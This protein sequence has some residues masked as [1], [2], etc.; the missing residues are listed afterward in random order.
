MQSVNRED[1]LK[2]TSVDM[3]TYELS[4]MHSHTNNSTYNIL[5][6]VYTNRY[7]MYDYQES[8][9]GIPSGVVERL[10]EDLNECEYINVYR[11]DLL[12]TVMMVVI[13]MYVKV[14]MTITGMILID[15]DGVIYV[16]LLIVLFV[17]FIVAVYVLYYC[18]VCRREHRCVSRYLHMHRVCSEYSNTH[19]IDVRLSYSTSYISIVC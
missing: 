17:V 6:D 8:I 10:V 15:R 16:Y 11:I 12:Y 7:D 9:Y 2:R 4:H 5:Y 1:I 18:I 13:G 19:D 14:C 3:H